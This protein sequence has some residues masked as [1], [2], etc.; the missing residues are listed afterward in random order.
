MSI[1]KDKAVSRDGKKFSIHMECYDNAMEVAQTCRTREITDRSFDDKSKE[2]FSDWEGVKTYDE[3]LELLRNG[4]QPTVEKM[5]GVFKANKSGEAKRF[6]FINNVQ[7]FAPVVPLAL[8]NVPNCMINM[9]MK[10]IKSKVVDVYYDMTASCS[11][12]SDKIIKAG[13]TLLG[14]IVELEKQGYRFNLYAVQTYSDTESCDMLVVKIKSSGQPL[15]LKR[16]SFPLTHTA[17]FRVV[18]FD[19]YSKVPGGKYRDGYGCGIAYKNT[20]EE[21]QNIAHQAFGKTAVYFSAAKII[22]T[23][24]EHVKEVLT[25]GNSKA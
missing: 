9:Q 20:E 22:K 14:T 2:R 8:K 3:A 1:I 15:D 18:G 19:W 11:T 12:D 17:F 6:S 23:D 24:K 21:L 16:I 25:N 13:Q 7:G 5:A 10:P 4:Y